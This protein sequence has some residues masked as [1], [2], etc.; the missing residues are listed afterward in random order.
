M[1]QGRPFTLDDLTDTDRAVLEH[2]RATVDACTK[3]WPKYTRQAIEFHLKNAAAW[4]NRAT[5]S[6]LAEHIDP[7]FVLGPS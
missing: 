1:D 6:D 3:D 2:M 7:G 4:A 5:G